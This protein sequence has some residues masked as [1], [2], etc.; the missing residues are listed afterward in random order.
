[1]A[2]NFHK[3]GIFESPRSSFTWGNGEGI[4]HTGRV[5]RPGRVKQRKP[6]SHWGVG[7]FGFRGER[8]AG[9]GE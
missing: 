3:S 9:G 7:A 5:L 1:M 6:G 8:F 4:G 2:G